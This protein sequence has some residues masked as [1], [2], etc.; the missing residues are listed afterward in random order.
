MTALRGDLPGP[1]LHPSL[2]QAGPR[3]G[4]SPKE[5][6]IFCLFSNC[7][8]QILFLLF[9]SKFETVI[10]YYSTLCEQHH[11]EQQ[12]GSADVFISGQHVSGQAP[13]T[14]H[15]P[16]MTPGCPRQGFP[17]K[18]EGSGCFI[19]AYLHSLFLWRA[20]VMHTHLPG[21]CSDAG[22]TPG[23]TPVAWNV[24]GQHQVP[25]HNCPCPCPVTHFKYCHPA[26][27]HSCLWWWC[28]RWGYAEA[29][30]S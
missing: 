10:V 14:G 3:A 21:L 27:W 5:K 12:P 20:K 13:S 28:V 19:G 25:E 30:P 23:P 15:S 9:L 8:F 4:G 11:S 18:T 24:P 1:A 29:F 7:C 16:G 2:A 6:G 26:R 17:H 22:V